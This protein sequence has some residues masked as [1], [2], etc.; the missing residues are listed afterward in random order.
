LILSWR[1]K[2]LTVTEEKKNQ[3]RSIR[4]LFLTNGV[5]RMR[6]IQELYPTKIAKALKIN[7]SRYIEKLYKPGKFTF[8][9]IWLLSS[10]LDID[11]QVIIDVIK[12]ELNNPVK[13][14]SKKKSPGK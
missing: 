9:H 12:K 13:A 2:E 3:F 7:H 11:V 5:S 6:D 10:L 4:S 1:S 8:D 14:I